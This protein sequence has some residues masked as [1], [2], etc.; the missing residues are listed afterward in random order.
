MSFAKPLFRTETGTGLVFHKN[1]ENLMKANAIAATVFLLIGGILAALVT[2]TRMPTLHILPAGQFYQALTGHGIDMLIIYIIFFEMAVLYFASST[3][4][5]SRLATPRWG[6]VQFGLMLVGALITNY[7]IIMGNSSVMMTSYVPMPA[8]PLF[9]LG[10]IL[11][12]VGALIGCFIFFGTLVIAKEE[13]SYEG[14][15]PLVVFGA[16]VA[17]II[18]V[19]TI[20]SGAI[21]LIP[22][23]LWSLGLISNIDPLMYRVIW[24][25][26]GHSSQQINVAAHIS[27]W[28]MVAALL[29]GAKPMSE[30][31]SRSAFLLYILFLQLASAHHIL[32]DP[33]VSSVWKVFNTS[34]AM[35]LAVLAS[36]IH[37]LTVPGSIE[38][39]QRMK[40]L[41]RGLFQ[42]LK[43]APWGNPVFSSMF[44]SLIG[45]GFLGGIS[46]VVMGVEQINLIIHNTIYVPGHFHATVV[47]GTTMAFM[48]VTYF[49]L[50]TLFGREIIF[51]SIAKLQPYL[52]GLGMAGV[53]L[54]LMGAGTMGVARRHWD[55]A[56]TGA[57]YAYEYPAI[58]YT[59]MGLAGIFAIL[60]VLGGAI[61]CLL[62]V[63]TL[64]FGKKA[65]SKVGF[66]GFRGI[67]SYTTEKPAMLMR[68]PADEGHG[69]IGMGWFIA[70]GTFVLALAFL[71]TFVLY[72][73]V[74]WKYLA[75][76]WGLA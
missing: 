4:L 75:S 49:L 17:A 59:I 33:G 42:W 25:A 35:Y 41:N 11:F 39:A 27:I 70:P 3:L 54:F 71:V 64:L 21:I 44:I 9:Y 31:I 36:M 40:G 5:R 23:F 29:F 20:A 51:P 50:P 2:A 37:G 8:D 6:W 32:V 26:L 47:L 53:S 43:K 28:Y 62:T 61:F 18:A 16:T 73:F 66:M 30:K 12:A 74:N 7:A 58:A 48:S 22:T 13:K 19:F 34:Y 46:G 76:V 68:A 52:F 45:F 15:V 57:P 67:D 56:F 69:K 38:V 55:M 72:Y 60:A 24:W 65:D 14:S 1:A 63:G 10:L